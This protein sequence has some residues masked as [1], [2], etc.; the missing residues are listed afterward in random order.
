MPGDK[1]I[2][3]RA[4][5]FGAIAEGE[6]TIVT[7]ILGRDNLGTI[8]IMR[9]LGVAVR[10]D[11]TRE[12]LPIAHDEGLTD[13]TASCGEQCTIHVTGRGLT[14][15]SAPDSALDC[16]NSGTTARLLCGLL[17]GQAFKCTLTGDASLSKRPFARVTKPLSDMGARFS[18]DRLPLTIEGGTLRG[19]EY[20]SPQA[21][22][23]V[24]SA[25][26]LAG[27]RTAE[28]VT[29]EEPRLSRDHTERML[30][31]MGCPVDVEMLAGGAARIMLPPAERR[32]TIRGQRIE[33]PGDFSAAAFFLIAASIIPGSDVT[34]RSV[35]FNRTRIGLFTL[36]E[37][38]GARLEV[39]REAEV[40][41]EPVVDIRVR[42]ARLRGIDVSAD[43]VVL[44]IDEIPIL[45]VAAAVAEGVTR[46]RGA[47]ELRVKESDR[48]AMTREV[49]ESFGGVATEADDGLDIHG[50]P[51]LAMSQAGALRG[52]QS[53]RWRHCGDHRISMSAAVFELLRTGSFA[54]AEREA[55]ET[56]FPSFERCLSGLAAGSSNG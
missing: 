5:I 46:I 12:L 56:S 39:V 29:V 4:I 7:S 28:G 43:D 40:G 11:V 20:R 35:L 36:L 2:T 19:I 6:S 47:G 13:F 42:S 51:A 30:T 18:G 49:L 16:G 52:G 10:G 38:M 33:V 55:V 41:G 53:G 25:I 31:S 9:Q 54:L 14:G 34:V 21:S 3:H 23:Q 22:A 45:S 44:A 1:S 8:R 27:L 32:G 17:A 26:I 15:L 50:N 24:K 48:I 37:R